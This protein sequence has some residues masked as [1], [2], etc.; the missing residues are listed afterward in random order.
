M[1][2][3]SQ[4]KPWG[5][6]GL[7]GL[8]SKWPVALDLAGS[9]SPCRLEGEIA[10]LVVF[11][12]IPKEIN[13]TFYRVMVDPFVPP[14]EGNVPIDGDGNI[15]AFRFHN[16]QV[17]MKM[18]YIETERYKLERQAGKALFGLYRN[19]FTHHP[20][21]RAAVDSTANTNLVY[22]AG[23]LLALK[24]VALPYA[25][26]PNT[27]ETTR[28]DPFEG[29]V[30]SKTFTAHPKVDPRTD[31]L[32]VFGYEAKGLATLDIVTYALDSRGRK[33]TE[34]WLKSPWCAF[35]HD[36]V[37]TENFIVL[38]LWPFESKMERMKQGKHHWAWNYDLP[39]TF[40]VVPRR[41]G[42]AAKYGWKDGEH[43]EYSWTNCMPIHTAGAWETEDGKIYAESSRVHDNAFPFFPPEDGRMPSPETKADF[44]RWE[45]DLSKPTGTTIPD[46]EVVL[47]LPSE[48]PRIDE[49]LMGTRY[50]WVFLNVFIPQNSDGRKNI[51]QGLNGL[52]MHNN[53]TGET[54]YFYAGDDAL[55]QEPIFIPRSETEADGWVMT[56]VERRAAN[57]CDIAV[58]DTQN[59]EK[60]VAIV[61]LPFHVK[62]QIHGN[63]VSASRLE[64][65]KRLVRQYEE[66]KISGKGAL[67]P[68]KD[69]GRG[70][71][72]RI[73]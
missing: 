48:F 32:V 33:T 41:P 58:I 19:P 54:R 38:F 72:C 6:D 11:G 52:A 40:L 56:L 71:L 13:G 49:R 60:P 46:P 28:Y 4:T 1:A 21:V 5:D 47:D 37:I 73:L 67:E 9:N 25:V 44:V 53:R 65:G 3:P 15:S 18:R 17:D 2:S 43:R 51:F 55:C 59:F 20:C 31:E 29:Q 61:Q 10:D 63:W 69:E 24:E 66:V 42:S 22:W 26:D 57:R 45:F 27:L 14:D 7:Y 23:Q 16:G 70:R 12:E 34:I 36:C 35:I 68:F 30:Q 50:D 62:A 39:V 64:P 8:V